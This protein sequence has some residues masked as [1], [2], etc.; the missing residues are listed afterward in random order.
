MNFDRDAVRRFEFVDRALDA[1]SGEARFRWRIEGDGFA[2]D[3]SESFFFDPPFGNRR[4]DSVAV[5]RALDLLHWVAGVSYWKLACTGQLAFAGRLP[6]RSQAGMLTM[7]YRDGLAEMAFRNG[8]KTQWWPEFPAADNDDC[9]PSSAA[10]LRRRA[11]VAIG[12]GK[13]SLVALERVRRCGQS[14]E[15][16]QIG[17][18]ALIAGSVRGR[19]P[20]HRQ[21][22]RRLSP[23]LVELNAAGALNG[24]VPITAINAAALVLAA[25]LWDF[26]AVV[27]ANERSADA[28]TLVSDAGLPINHQFAKSLVFEQ[29]LGD[30]VQCGIAPDLEVFSLLRRDSELAI[31]RDFAGL[32]SCHARF[33]SCNRNF[34]LDGPRTGRWCLECP[35]CLFVY[36]CL[37]PFLDPQRMHRIFGQDLLATTDRLDGFVALLEVNG[38]RPFECVGEAGEARAAVQLLAEHPAWKSHAAVQR[39]AD[40]LAGGPRVD[41]A[42]LLEPSARHRIPARFLS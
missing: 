2:V 29:A 27:F 11:L 19:S 8:L 33:S 25:L 38:H 12:G 13:D 3:F 6:N 4:V 40:G 35:K 42:C 28:P 17:S 14:F 1:E 24:H 39:L 36:L 16:A 15:T 5:E 20:R 41:V 23:K 10:G 9:A 21:I 22:G 37:A 31:C 32:D 7:L 34:H 30:W 18:A 26:D